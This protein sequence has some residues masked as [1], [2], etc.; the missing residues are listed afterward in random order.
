MKRT[1]IK[2]LIIYSI[3]FFIVNYFNISD[4]DAFGIIKV[5]VIAVLCGAALSGIT[6]LLKINFVKHNRERLKNHNKKF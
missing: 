1:F 2:L 4:A 6:V 3:L 5:I